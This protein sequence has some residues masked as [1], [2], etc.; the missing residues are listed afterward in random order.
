MG[1]LLGERWSDGRA[2]DW[3]GALRVPGVSLALYGKGEAR[4]GRKMGHLVAA[5]ETSEAARGVLAAAFAALGS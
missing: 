3:T 1:N 5:G 2:P 4:P